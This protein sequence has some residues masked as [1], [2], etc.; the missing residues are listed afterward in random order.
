MSDN[1]GPSSMTWPNI[2][3]TFNLQSYITLVS[4]SVYYVAVR[5]IVGTSEDVI[6]GFFW[7]VLQDLCE[8]VLHCNKIHIFLCLFVLFA[9]YY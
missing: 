4:V 6:F 9:L 8:F 2:G 7:G 1:V 3:A 5:T